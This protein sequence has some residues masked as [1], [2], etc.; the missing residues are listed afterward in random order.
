MAS[1][2][3]KCA[4]LWLYYYTEC[5]MLSALLLATWAAFATHCFKNGAPRTWT[6]QWGRLMGI[7]I[8]IYYCTL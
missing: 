3:Q 4:N 8:L 2:V 1:S 7:G 6:I 5:S